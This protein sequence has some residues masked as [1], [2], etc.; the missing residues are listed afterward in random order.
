VIEWLASALQISTDEARKLTT[1]RSGQMM[2][3]RTSLTENTKRGIV[4]VRASKLEYWVF[5]SKSSDI[6]VRRAAIDAAGG[7]TMQG[8]LALATG[9]ERTADR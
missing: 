3:F 5:T 7:D 1:L 6:P 8:L 9:R 2:L 4:D